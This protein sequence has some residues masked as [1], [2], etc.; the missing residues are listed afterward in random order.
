MKALRR[1]SSSCDT[2]PVLSDP[3]AVMG[4]V[5]CVCGLILAA[6]FRLL[7]TG[8]LLYTLIFVLCLYLKD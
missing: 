7:D 4:P 2:G 3:P 5:G 6:H 1:G 8:M